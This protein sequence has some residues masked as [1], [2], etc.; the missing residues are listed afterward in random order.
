MTKNSTYKNQLS[1]E[2]I[3]ERIFK[4]LIE[5]DNFCEQNK[6]HY[7]LAGGT[8]LGAVRHKGFIP[9]DDDIDVYMPR[10]DYNILI[11]KFNKWG[12][13]HYRLLSSKTP[14]FYMMISKIIDT[15]TIAVEHDRCE[16]IG[17]WIDILP[18][19]YIDED[20]PED[21]KC[22][23]YRNSEELYYMGSKKYFASNSFVKNMAKKIIRFFKKIRINRFYKKS[24]ERYKGANNLCFY[25]KRRKL[26]WSKLPSN[27]GICNSSIRLE[28]ENR[29]FQVMNEWRTYLNI[30]FGND[31]MKLPPIEERISHECAIRTAK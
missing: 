19:E 25:S 7:S 20:M 22:K 2:E 10:N 11:K 23:L 8:L 28:F 9:W 24:I 27:L 15:T 5:F 17:V 13:H 1:I 26:V 30:Y 14:G 12:G 16:K 18:V 29:S 3:K 31:Y 6:L 4:I 21:V